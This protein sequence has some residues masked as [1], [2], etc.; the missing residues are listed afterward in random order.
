MDQDRCSRTTDFFFYTWHNLL[1]HENPAPAL[2]TEQLDHLQLRQWHQTYNL[3]AFLAAPSGSTKPRSIN[4]LNGVFHCEEVKSQDAPWTCHPSITGVTHTDRQT[5]S[6]P[7]AICVSQFHLPSVS[8]DCRRKPTQKHGEH[9]TRW[10][11]GDRTNHWEAAPH[12]WHL[13]CAAVVKSKCISLPALCTSTLPP[14]CVV[15]QCQAT[16]W[17]YLSPACFCVRTRSP[18][19]FPFCT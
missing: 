1:P 18:H 8:L 10:L 6:N 11:R 3:S 12:I 14:F 7:Q 13:T 5:H 19:F 2:P 16:A 15:F 4:F 9:E 17:Y